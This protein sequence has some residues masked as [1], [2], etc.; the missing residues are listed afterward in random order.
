MT[1]VRVA[2]IALDCDT[3]GRRYE[4][5]AQSAVLARIAAATTGWQYAEGKDPTRPVLGHP[6]KGQRQFDYCAD[7][8]PA[9]YHA[10]IRA[11]GKGP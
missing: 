4:S 3:C 8:W 7:C 2:F 11:E 1:V 9:S 6:G 10:K 5:D